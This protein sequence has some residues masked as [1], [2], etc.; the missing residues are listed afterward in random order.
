MAEKAKMGIEHQAID[1]PVG[2]ECLTTVC[3]Y[4]FKFNFIY[5][6]Y[7]AIMVHINGI[8]YIVGIFYHVW[9]YLSYLILISSLRSNFTEQFVD[10]I[11]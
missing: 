7:I 10:I 11:N 1:I 9:Y 8:L 6:T 3:T 2:F 5:A 4:L